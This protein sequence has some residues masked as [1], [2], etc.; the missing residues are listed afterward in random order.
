MAF[1]GFTTVGSLCMFKDS[2]VAPKVPNQFNARSQ[3][4]SYA[5][6][7]DIGYTVLSKGFTLP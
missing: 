4:I 3:E 6:R 2:T 5:S 1:F 7:D